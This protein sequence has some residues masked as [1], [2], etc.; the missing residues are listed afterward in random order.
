MNQ[1]WVRIDSGCGQDH[2]RNSFVVEGIGGE[3]GLPCS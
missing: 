1:E 3:G 2:V